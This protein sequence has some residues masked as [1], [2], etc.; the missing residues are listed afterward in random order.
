MHL[1]QLRSGSGPCFLRHESDFIKIY[2]PILLRKKSIAVSGP[3][4]WDCLSDVIRLSAS[5]S[6]YKKM[7]MDL[8]KGSYGNT[9]ES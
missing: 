5:L 6:I 3:E 8:L 7:L 2:Y 1:L 4:L 9:L